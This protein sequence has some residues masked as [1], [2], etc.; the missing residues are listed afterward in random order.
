MEKPDKRKAILDAALDLFAEKG[1]HGAPTS[2]LAQHAGVGV[3]TIYRY[4]KD[5]DELIRELY[6]EV[7][8]RVQ[9][10]VF[11]DSPAG[12]PV[13]ER[14]IR[15]MSRLLRFFLENPL[16]FRF[17]EQY[18]FSPFSTDDDCAAPEE[19][20][21]I[22]QMLITARTEHIV[23]EAHISVL[24]ALAFGPLVA[25]AKEHI[26][27]NV[28]VDEEMIRQTVEASWDGLKR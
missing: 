6:R 27:R 3:G 24:Q 26:N 25:L 23:K 4:F 7:R 21:T 19:N 9:V 5:K 2:L 28:A 14:Y 1:F 20:E 13:R 11:S 17:M 18:Y 12:L 8:E 10:R 16:E 15:S 22:R